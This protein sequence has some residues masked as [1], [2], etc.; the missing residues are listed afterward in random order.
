VFCRNRKA[1]PKI[2]IESQDTPNG[3][4][5][6]EKKNKVGKFTMIENNLTMA[7]GHINQ[8]KKQRIERNPTTWP[9]T[10]HKGGAKTIQWRKDSLPTNVTGSWTFACKKKKMKLDP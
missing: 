8:W 6:L 4:N 5:N 1:Y 7:Y 10:F 3:H 2:H 9:T